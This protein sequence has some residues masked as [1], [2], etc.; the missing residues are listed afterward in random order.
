MQFPVCN[1]LSEKIVKKRYEDNH[2]TPVFTVKVAINNGVCDC[3]CVWLI[4]CQ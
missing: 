4:Y 1:F 2:V 3:V